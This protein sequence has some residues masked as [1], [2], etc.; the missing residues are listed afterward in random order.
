VANVVESTGLRRRPAQARSAATFDA[1]LASAAALLESRGVAAF[2]T[3]ALAA[4]S[5]IS[6]RAIYRYFP[7]KQA[8]IVELAQRM[9]IEW[10]Q[11]VSEVGDLGDPAQQWETVWCGYLDA[12]VRSVVATV[13]GRAVI[14]AMRDDPELRGVDDEINERYVD[15]VSVA[16]RQRHPAL[17][18][19]ASDVA[20]RV[21]MRSTIG[22]LDEAVFAEGLRR[23]ALI[24]ALQIMHVHYLRH[25]LEEESRGVHRGS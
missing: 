6:V 18:V 17:S 1:L 8:I 15:G 3:N 4:E 10:L 5:G 21:L 2:S 19:A 12:W 20:A 25:V 7:N 9:S 22:V 11:A 14:A 13:G 16:L 23:S 24:A